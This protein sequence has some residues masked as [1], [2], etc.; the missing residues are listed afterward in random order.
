MIRGLIW[1]L[2]GVLVRTSD[3]APRTALAA[4]YGA[5]AA[6]LEELV[7]G[8]EQ[9]R[10]AQ[11]GLITNEQRW[12][13]IRQHFSLSEAG[14]EQFKAGFWGGDFVDYELIAFIRHLRGRYKTALLSN[15]FSNLRDMVTN[16]WGFADAFDCMVISAEEN[17]MKPDARIYQLVVERLGVQPGEAVLIDDFIRN[18]DGARAAGL[19]AI[20]FLSPEQARHDLAQLLDQA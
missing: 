4:S 2:G 20:Q 18:L 10:S 9:G 5:S 7:F 6:D 12:E 3:W 16:T 1:D 15:A 8:G 17:L 19:H 11:L 14:L 13:L